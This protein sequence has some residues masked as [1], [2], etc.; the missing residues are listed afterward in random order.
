MLLKTVVLCLLF[1]RVDKK[2]MIDILPREN[3][4]MKRFSIAI[5]ALLL[6]GFLLVGFNEQAFSIL[7]ESTSHVISPEPKI[8]S[9]VPEED[10]T[11]EMENAIKRYSELYNADRAYRDI[12]VPQKA[13][14]IGD[15]QIVELTYLPGYENTNVTERSSVVRV[16]DSRLDAFDI[17]N[18]YDKTNQC[19][20]VIVEPGMSDEIAVLLK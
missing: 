19:I 4:R 1:V 16:E 6:L 2:S 12:T 10:H 13:L 5:A 8:V 14:L 7:T 11:A 15:E 3:K 17:V 9:S 20:S 18:I